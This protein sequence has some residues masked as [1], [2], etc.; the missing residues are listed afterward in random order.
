MLTTFTDRMTSHWVQSL[1]LTASQALITGWQQLAHAMDRVSSGATHWQVLQLPTGS[2]KTEALKVLCSIQDEIQ[3]P[4]VLIVTKF[5]KEADKLAESI[6]RH[7]GWKM[8]RSAHQE[9][10]GSNDE[11]GFAPVLVTT[12]VAYKLALREIADTGLTIKADRLL[13][14]YTGK[15]SWLIID[16]AFEWADTYSLIASNLRS[17]S[18]DLTR[19]MQGEMRTAAEQLYEFSGRLT[20]T[21]H[22]QSDRP[23]ANECID[24]L[25]R[26]DL[27][28]LKAGVAATPEDAFA[29]WAEHRPATKA[30]PTTPIERPSKAKYFDQLTELE[31][32]ARIGHGWISK[33]G[34]RTQLHS[35][36]SLI[37]VDGMRG[38]ILDAT[39][40]IDPT[41]SLLRDQIGL[42]PRPSGIRTYRNVTLHLSYGHRV[43][44]EHLA[45]NAGKE[46]ALV[47]GDLSKRLSG[48]SV[49]V[50]A[51]KN[52]LP[53]IEQYGP[54]D[55]YVHFENWG[56]LD[57]KNDWNTCQAAILFGLP[58][59]DDLEPAQRF[60]AYQGRQ[61]GEWFAG[62]RKYEEHAD[63]RTA[64]NDGFIAK[65]VVQAINRIHCRNAID[66]NG[67]CKPTDIFLLLPSGSTGTVVVGAIRQQMPGIRVADWLSG[68]TRRKARKIPTEIKLIEHFSSADAGHYRKSEILR[69]LRI[70]PSS[71]ERMTAKLRQPTSVLAMKLE[72]YGV[73][74]H[75]QT[76]RGREAYFIKQ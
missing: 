28:G 32:I 54:R 40:H 70:N 34:A 37:G 25:L 30:E 15:R 2:G 71:L 49:L 51:H 60:I 50:C 35:S 17:M 44:K 62:S 20:D 76:G 7:A 63:I 10:P 56:N 19:A 9:A 12:H 16:E 3:H 55:G 13:N 26:I 59:L 67:N 53:V 22:G 61:S 74:Y 21:R 57:G 23:V 31:T 36:R 48:K 18:G 6:N 8:A 47:W 11:L 58:Y 45:R 73:R 4:G 68:A 39:A 41:Y 33:R 38:V 75:S 69:T 1:G 24:L 66:A 64:L 52:A 27:P 29:E 42:L 46:W 5:R 14:Y 43:G 65:S 72:A